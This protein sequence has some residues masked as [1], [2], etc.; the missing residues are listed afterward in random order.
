MNFAPRKERLKEGRSYPGGL[1]YAGPPSRTSRSRQSTFVI[2]G[3]ICFALMFYVFNSGISAQSAPDRLHAL[4]EKS[5]ATG[6]ARVVLEDTRSQHHDGH[7]HPSIPEPASA[8]TTK[9]FRAPTADTE[10]RPIQVPVDFHGEHISDDD[11]PPSASKGFDS[12]RVLP[13]SATTHWSERPKFE[14]ALAKVINML[15]GEMHMR[16]LLRQVDGTGKEKLRE[17]GLRVRAY[18]GYFEA[19][20]QLHLDTDAE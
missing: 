7:Q 2:V 16:D 4:L 12:A 20:E 19:W 11:E 10:A 17:M 13:S 14:K 9:P 15:P 6:E 1:P 8:E 18:K 5:K 3:L